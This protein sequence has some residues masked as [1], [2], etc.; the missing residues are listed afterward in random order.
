MPPR[1]NDPAQRP[2]E[3]P[4]G[5]AEPPPDTPSAAAP[6]SA[7]ASQATRRNAT[8]WTGPTPP[9]RRAGR[10]GRPRLPDSPAVEGRGPEARDRERRGWPPNHPNAATARGAA[11][12]ERPS[13]AAAA[14][15]THGPLA[16]TAS[17]AAVRCIAWFGPGAPGRTADAHPRPVHPDLSFSLRVRGPAVGRQVRVPSMPRAGRRV[18]ATVGAAAAQPPARTAGR[19]S[20][21]LPPN[22]PAHPP[23]KWRPVSCNQPMTV[24]SA[25]GEAPGSAGSV[26][27]ATHAPLQSRL[28]AHGPT[29]RFP[30]SASAP[31]TL[32]FR[33]P[34]DGSMPEGA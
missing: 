19:L 2:P 14:T 16:R 24:R 8:A 30:P 18:V 22:D 7:W 33:L 21:P 10:R 13:S 26:I 28:S 29:T 23:P 4:I 25:V 15:I 11:E 34:L 9:R 1:P 17:R 27:P 3:R 32:D 20:V 31:P 6:G 5:A 12:A